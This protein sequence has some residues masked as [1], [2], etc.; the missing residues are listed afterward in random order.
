MQNRQSRNHNCVIY[1]IN[2]LDENK[3]D[4]ITLEDE[5][6]IVSICFGH[7]NS[8]AL[9][10]SARVLIWGNNSFWQLGLSLVTDYSKI[11]DITSEFDLS[12]GEKIVSLSSGG[13]HFSAVTS[14]N[15]VFMWGSND[16]GQLGTGIKTDSKSLFDMT[17]KFDLRD[18]EMIVSVTL[19]KNHSSAITS[20]NRLFTW[21]SNSKGQL[22]DGTTTD[23]DTPVD[24]T[25]RFNLNDDETISLVSL[26]FAHSSALTSFGRVFVW[27]RNYLG[28]LG[29]GTTT[30][31]YTP[32]DITSQFYLLGEEKIVLMSLGSAHSAVLTSFGRVFTWGSNRFYQLCDS[33]MKY[34]SWP[35]KISSQFNLTHREHIVSLSLGGQTF[36]CTY[37]VRK[38]FHLGT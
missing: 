24:I 35:I 2:D 20:F 13:S 14:L 33:T 7:N 10:S 9:T 16:Y 23:R 36:L 25:S 5:E 12:K 19:G 18:G 15:R 22:G 28:Q 8:C 3:K 32:I 31:R 6:T 38:S 1:Q 37:F 21:G 30:D 11:A 4:N 29:D 27:G 34:S 26:G 17:S